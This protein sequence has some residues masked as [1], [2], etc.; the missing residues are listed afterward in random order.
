MFVS[1]EEL[2]EMCAWENRLAQFE[3]YSKKTEVWKDLVG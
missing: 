3:R 2:E 1:S